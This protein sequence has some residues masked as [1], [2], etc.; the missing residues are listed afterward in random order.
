MI[1]KKGQ[2]EMVGFVLI[3]VMLIFMGIAFLFL[4][5]PKIESRTDL[6]TAN[7]LTAMIESTEG[8][9]KI[10]EMIENC[11]NGDK[12]NETK[13]ALEKRLDASL[14]KSGL[15]L[16]RTLRGYILNVSE[17]SRPLFEQPIKKGNLT[18]NNLAS[19]VPIQDVDVIL[20]FYY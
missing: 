17:G 5:R 16:G 3:V 18:G 4:A 7:L 1:K 8:N 10:R 2:E 11:A 14:S 9:M 19:L 13:I 15:V 20:K 12:C 6:Q